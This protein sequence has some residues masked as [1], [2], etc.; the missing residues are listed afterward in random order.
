VAKAYLVGEAAEAF[1]RTLD[2]KA[3]YAIVGTIEAAVA[4]AYADARKTRNAQGV[5]EA[6]VLLSPACASFD[7]FPDFEVRGEAFRTAAL[8]LAYQNRREACA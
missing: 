3:D 4:A 2:G 6:V 8:A 7:Q 5:E 1:G